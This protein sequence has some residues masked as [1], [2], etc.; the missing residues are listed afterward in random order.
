MSVLEDAQAVIV[1]VEVALYR[2]DQWLLIRRAEGEEHAG[3]L[4]SLVGGKAEVAGPTADILEATVIREAAEEI[5][6]T[7]VGP[8][9]YANSTV[10]AMPDG[11]PVINVVLVASDIRG[12]PRPASRSEVS[13]IL[14]LTA[15]EIEASDDIPPWTKASV[16]CAE[17]HRRT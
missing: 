8:F 9:R 16:S 4:L 7:P 5:G 14:W 6:A 12:E 15:E 3:G 10:F 2:G 13:E 17:V 11:T 1:N